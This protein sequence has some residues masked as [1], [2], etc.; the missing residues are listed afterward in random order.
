MRFMRLFTYL[1]NIPA[2]R[3]SMLSPFAYMAAIFGL[4]SIP[5]SP[6]SHYEHEWLHQI[7]I[8]LTNAIHIPLFAGLAWLWRWSLSAT[9]DNR[10]FMTSLA[11]CLTVAYGIFDEWHQS[12]TPFR[13]SS[14]MDIM[15]DAT[16]A[17]VAL[18]LFSK[19][20]LAK[21]VATHINYKPS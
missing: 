3:H 19:V 15:L 13:T 12:F 5:G 16:G 9:M 20:A 1:A 2:T 10:R 11:F 6:P 14:F 21:D 7:S 8:A 18:W 17:M 4:S